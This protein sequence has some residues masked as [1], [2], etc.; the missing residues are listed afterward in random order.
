ME[1]TPMTTKLMLGAVGLASMCVVGN[2]S[3]V[4]FSPFDARA[5]GMGGTGVA[6]AKSASAANFNPAL[7]ASQ[8]DEDDFGMIFP[9][10]GLIATDADDL[11]DGIDGIQDNNLDALS[12][13]ITASN[14]PAIEQAAGDLAAALRD[15]NGDSIQLS[16]G[17]GASFSIPSKK[18]GVALNISSFTTVAIS[19]EIST[20]DLAAID[21]IA[22]GYTGQADPTDSLTSTV[23]AVAVGVVEVGL[24][25][26]RAF[27]SAGGW[28]MGIT[29]KLQQVITYDYQVSFDADE[30]EGF[31][32][33]DIS[34]SEESESFFNVDVG[35]SKQFGSTK[36]WQV[37][38]VVKNLIEQEVTSALGK[39][40]SIAPQARI[41]LAHSTSWS[42]VAIDLDL[43]ENDSAI[44]GDSTQYLA[45][46]IELNAFDTA[47]IRLGYRHNLSDDNG[48]DLVTAGLGLSPLGISLEISAIASENTVGLVFQTGFRF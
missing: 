33:G 11:I 42:T 28:A 8:S 9:A 34:D 35:F 2:V 30:G 12:D 3:A 17:G 1:H 27:N 18:F 5:M 47:Q 10:L 21:S 6:S 48:E 46:G 15:I 22:V 4:P 7:L 44:V 23:N 45:A 25:F 19:P 20:A 24:T 36:S 14:I 31:D 40:L 26:A 16:L 37:G 32:S 39:T 38:L 41:G 29:P 43:T 13:A